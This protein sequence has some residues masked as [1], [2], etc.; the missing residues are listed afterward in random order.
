MP[1]KIVFSLL[2]EGERDK[3]VLK[4][5]KV[6]LELSFFLSVSVSEAIYTA[7]RRIPIN[8]DSGPFPS[9]RKENLRMCWEKS[10]FLSVAFVFFINGNDT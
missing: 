1:L 10:I 8:D 9:Y 5:A 3:F 2:K 6:S 4:D 7:R